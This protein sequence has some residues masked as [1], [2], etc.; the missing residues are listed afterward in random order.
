MPPRS[1]DEASMKRQEWMS[2]FGDSQEAD[3]E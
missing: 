1:A 3:E 2:K